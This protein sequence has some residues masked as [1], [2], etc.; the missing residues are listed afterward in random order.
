MPH[1]LSLQACPALCDPMDYSP[2]DSYVHRILPQEHWN[3]WPALVHKYS[4]YLWFQVSPWGVS[5]SVSPVDGGNYCI[6]M[7]LDLLFYT[8]NV[9]RIVFAPYYLRIE[10][11]M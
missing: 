4:H 7:Y 1:M 6:S 8:H 9:L 10:Q 2:P 11:C 5:W 3:G